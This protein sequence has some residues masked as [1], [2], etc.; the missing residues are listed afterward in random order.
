[1]LIHVYAEYCMKKRSGLFDHVG[2]LIFLG[3]L[4]LPGILWGMLKLQWNDT[5]Q[6]RFAFDLGENRVLASWPSDCSPG[7]LPGALETYYNDHLPFRSHLISWHTMLDNRTENIYRN[8]LQPVLLKLAGKHGGSSLSSLAEQMNGASAPGDAGVSAP[9]FRSETE[10]GAHL[11]EL[12]RQEPTC[13]QEGWILLQDPDTG[14]EFTEVL[15]AAGHREEVVEVLEPT[16]LNYGHTIYECSVCGHR[17]WGDFK[18]KFIDDSYFPGVIVDNDVILGRFHWLF[19]RGNRSLDYY[20]GNNLFTPEECAENLLRLQ[21]LQD[22]CD[23]KGITLVYMVMPNKEQVYPEYMPTYEIKSEKKRQ[24]AFRDYVLENSDINYLYPLEELTLG[25][26]YYDTY[27]PYDTHWNYWGAFVGVQAL[28]KAMG[29]EC[30][31]LQE[32]KVSPVESK[33]RVLATTGSLDPAD[34]TNDCDYYVSYKENLSPTCVDGVKGLMDGHTT[35]YESACPD[36]ACDQKLVCI[37]DSFRVSMI[38]TM[39]K[40]F[41]ETVFVHRDYMSQAKAD[42][43]EA[44]ILLVTALER[45]DTELFSTADRLVSYLSE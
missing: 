2:N 11:T 36:A 44:D 38:D 18:D 42:V 31:D 35:R 22:I 29:L 10:A 23:Q 15:P 30:V 4:I 16:Y 28:Y 40:D 20:R 39:E 1:M 33:A 17:R 45:F 24:Q 27:Y 37:G 13:T 8:S 41:S 26:L 7:E 6:E 34:Y 43:Q 32:V 19:Y 25:K 12:S 21:A 9:D 5:L 14:E 3:I